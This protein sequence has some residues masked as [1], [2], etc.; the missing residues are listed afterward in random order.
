MPSSR[1]TRLLCNYIGSNVKGVWADEG[2]E[3]QKHISID[4]A[5]VFPLVAA[6][7]HVDNIKSVASVAG[8]EVHEGLIGTCTNGRIEDLRTAASVLKGA[9][10][11]E[12]FQL[13]IIPASKEIYLQA[14]REGLI[15]DLIEAGANI[16]VPV[17]DHG[18]GTGR[19]PCSGHYGHINGNR[20]FLGRRGN[21]GGLYFSPRRDG[22]SSAI[23]VLSLT[24]ELQGQ[25]DLPLQP[26]RARPIPLQR[27]EQ[28]E[29]NVWNYAE[30]TT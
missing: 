5:G 16:S 15:T 22:A 9:K 1:M 27:R 28:R 26:R 14:I 12:G 21:K 8:T 11:K 24:R 2:A 17:A 10:V 3:Y 30:W 4:L 20:N 19:H 13:H 25:R 18:L 7:H 6:P 29:G 23:T